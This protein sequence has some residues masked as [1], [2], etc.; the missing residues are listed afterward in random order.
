VAGTDE[1][2]PSTATRP[3]A[4]Q[5]ALLGLAGAAAT[6]S[7][8]VA[9]P[10]S[11]TAWLCVPVG[12]AASWSRRWAGAAVAA[13]TALLVLRAALSERAS[14][15]HALMSVV[16]LVLLA[17][18]VSVAVSRIR[19]EDLHL[20][21]RLEEEREHALRASAERDAL[22]RRLTH[23]AAHD[24]LT[25]LPNRS[26][27]L[28]RL[29]DALRQADDGAVVGVLFL[30]LDDFK[31]VN[32]SL[33]H[34]AGDELLVGI[35]RRLENTLRAGDVV[36][37]FGGDEFAVLLLS[38]GTAE[39][40][41]GVA[42]RLLGVLRAP[43]ALSAGMASGQA[44]GGLVLEAR[45]PSR[46]VEEQ[47][48][49]LVRQADLAMY[50]A[51]AAGGGRCVEFHLELQE[52]M[53]ERLALQ[54]EITRALIEEQFSLHY[55]PVVDLTTK[56]LVAVEAL[57]RWHHPERGDISPERFIP[58]AERSGAIVPL[59]LWV[60]E[61]ACLD[62]QLWDEL[63]PGN[64]LRISVNISARQ[65]RDRGVGPQIA[66]ILHKVGVDPR[67]LV[68]EVTESMLMD[69]GETATATLWQLRALGIRIAIDDFGTG[70]SSLSRLVDLP[71]DDLK[72][73]RTFIDEL[74]RSH[75]GAT[76]VTAAI[77]M[78]HGLGLK[79]VAEGVETQDQLDFLTDAAC[80]QA[81]GYLFSPPVPL[82]AVLGM[83]RRGATAAPERVPPPRSQPG[84]VLSSR[85]TAR[86]IPS[87]PKHR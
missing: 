51:K 2:P 14:A 40:V 47:G 50:S 64:D 36:A 65:L 33:G 59:G 20:V 86:V 17:A 9:P 16:A 66:R 45:D 48:G 68:L 82:D 7:S 1:R 31:T 11:G 56:R 13:A 79:V 75:A 73:D 4:A 12:L 34:A 53:R 23:Q 58:I 29:N 49:D 61:Q 84:G 38:G 54:D 5:A 8:L 19:R 62:L 46:T 80:D 55:Q 70:Y 21:S 52:A 41:G 67:R 74:T 76:I 35:S 26:L 28:E 83:L 39:Q 6:V 71:L 32:D 15:G 60:L 44:S 22:S 69:D 42:N 77:A 63:A 24:A 43:F 85:P 27:F 72:V 57:V 10:L 25:G 30:D 81:Q 18:T 78:A 3:R 87:L 37:R